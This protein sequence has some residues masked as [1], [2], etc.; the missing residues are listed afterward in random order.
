M[1]PKIKIAWIVLL[2]VGIAMGIVISGNLGRRQAQAKPGAGE[3]A[4]AKAAV[5][6]ARSIGIMEPREMY[7]PGT[8]KLAP[9]EMR[10]VAC[11]TDMPAS[12]GEI[13]VHE[14]DYISPFSFGHSRKSRKA[15]NEGP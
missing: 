4:A 9:D 7:F 5:E 8:E 11:G 15:H 14:F 12:G 1:I 6:K 13:E 10:V 2:A 3:G